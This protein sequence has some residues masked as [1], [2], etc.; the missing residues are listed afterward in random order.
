MSIVHITTYFLPPHRLLLHR[1]I[2]G[3][4]TPTRR[5]RPISAAHCQLGAWS[6]ELGGLLNSLSRSSA[7]ARCRGPRL[8]SHVS[9]GSSSDQEHASPSQNPTLRTPIQRQPS[10]P[11]LPASWFLPVPSSQRPT[12]VTREPF[13]TRPAGLHFG[14]NTLSASHLYRTRTR[15][16]THPSSPFPKAF[17]LPGLLVRLYPS[18]SSKSTSTSTSNIKNPQRSGR[19]ENTQ[20]TPQV[21]GVYSV[22]IVL[23]PVASLRLDVRNRARYCVVSS[24]STSHPAGPAFC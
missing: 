14:I 22:P 15:T 5:A 6:L 13:K 18:F 11:S 24:A 7:S 23:P 17:I 10:P 19:S 8:T 21:S 12:T 3:E 2:S 4:Q 20:P 16:R 9:K 1:H